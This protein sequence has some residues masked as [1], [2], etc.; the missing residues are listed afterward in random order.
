MII[1]LKGADFSNNNIGPLSSWLISRE[2]GDG[3]RYSGPVYVSKGGAFSATVVLG[4]GYRLSGEIVVTMG[5]TVVPSAFTIS[6]DGKTINFTIAEVIGN[7]YIT[8][9]T[10]YVQIYHTI[11]YVFVDGAGNSIKE[12]ETALALEG[13]ELEFSTLNAPD[14]ED[15]IIN[16]VEPI[17][18]TITGD[19]TVTYTYISRIFE[20]T[21]TNILTSYSNKTPNSSQT[22]GAAIGLGEQGT[23]GT[24][25]WE[26]P[27]DGRIT[28]VVKSGGTYGMAL[29]DAED[30]VLEYTTNAAIFND[31]AEGV[32]TFGVYRKPTKLYV[33]TTKFNSANYKLLSENEIK[34]LEYAISVTE[35]IQTNKFP[36]SSGQIVGE[37]IKYTEM[38]ATSTMISEV[39]PANTE[40]EVT[41]NAVS[42][43]YGMVLC[44]LDGKV[45][46][47]SSN[48]KADENLKLIFP[49]QLVESRLYVA[50]NKFTSASY[51]Y[52]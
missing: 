38:N 25:V 4:S 40:I 52:V 49:A 18:A 26:I 9:P 42:G 10:E 29:T 6:E 36:A 41:V 27:A 37:A 46:Y 5:E 33:A 23:L 8:V 13:A 30:N 45:L 24:L 34:E 44:D 20:L 2:I 43:A 12:P 31:N 15:F 50:P 14:I 35:T 7:I 17:N 48:N 16:S 51:K 28:L 22:I 11:T 47:A 19:I 1:T 21:R 3:A 32:Y 39:I